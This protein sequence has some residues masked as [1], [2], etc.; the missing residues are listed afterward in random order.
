[1]LKVN[2]YFE[3]I[4]FADDDLEK[5]VKV[6]ELQNFKKNDFVVE[7]GK[8]S[9]YMGFVETG[10]FQ[11]YVIKD[12]EERT[13]YVSI[14]NTFFASV[15]SFI[16]EKPSLEN[17]KAL[18]DGSISMLSKTNLKMLLNEIPAFKDF[19]IGLLEATLCGID[20]SRYDL[21]VLTAEQR[22]EK[23]LL[24]EPHLL[25]QIPLQHLASMLGVTPRHL[26]RI[27]SKIR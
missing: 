19:Y 9:R 10:M 2:K 21:I 24:N 1:M 20:A 23:M 4:G 13:S 8:T 22:Y 7:E 26:S 14:E 5:I 18:V 25:Q 15:L 11:Y 16:S 17:V 27:R 12:G 6:F 3:T